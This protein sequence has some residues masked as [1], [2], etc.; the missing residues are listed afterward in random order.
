MVFNNF[1]IILYQI[2]L[3]DSESP[4]TTL[5]Y[6]GNM[7]INIFMFSTATVDLHWLVNGQV[8]YKRNSLVSCWT[9]SFN[10]CAQFVLTW[11]GSSWPVPVHTAQWS[12][13]VT[14]QSKQI[15]VNL[16]FLEAFGYILNRKVFLNIFKEWSSY[17]TPKKSSK[18]WKFKEIWH[19]KGSLGQIRKSAHIGIPYYLG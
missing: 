11:L 15:E 9:L 6:I 10:A 2:D 17:K 12:E 1:N 4:K 3:L 19:K 7:K 8:F 13:G 16:S 14:K 18:I 5:R